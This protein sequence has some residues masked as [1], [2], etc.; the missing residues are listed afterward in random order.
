[1]EQQTS[2]NSKLTKSGIE[3]TSAV[4]DPTAA[5]TILDEPQASIDYRFKIAKFLS[6]RTNL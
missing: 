5:I 1:M 2:K 6:E 3:L 4:T